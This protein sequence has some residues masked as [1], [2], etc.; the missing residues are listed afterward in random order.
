[1]V[2]D[3]SYFVSSL[4]L[5]RLVEERAEDTRLGLQLDLENLA[6]SDSDDSDLMRE[7]LQ[8]LKTTNYSEPSQ[9]PDD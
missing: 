4:K 5:R 1:M 8:S 2:D 6:Y 9:H 7:Y 3:Y